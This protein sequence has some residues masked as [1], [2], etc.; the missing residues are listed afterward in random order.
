LKF[1]GKRAAFYRGKEGAFLS[2][3][4]KGKKKGEKGALVSTTGEIP[5][6]GKSLLP[7]RYDR[8]DSIADCQ[9]EKEKVSYC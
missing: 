4:K 8:N 1:G 7:Y 9:E 3:G 5:L 6:S 2:L